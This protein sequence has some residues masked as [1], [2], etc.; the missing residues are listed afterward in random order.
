LRGRWTPDAA[1]ALLQ[2]IDAQARRLETV[3]RD[4]AQR[5]G[6]WITLPEGMAVEE[7]RGGLRALNEQ[8]ITVDRLIINRLTPPPRQ[9]CGWC[10]GR[11][12]LEREAFLALE[13]LV[14]GTVTLA[15]VPAAGKEP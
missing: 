13:R 6:A 15:T 9:P 12:S 10:D 1:D 3:L 7:T 11:R 5:E 2:E 8:N 4:P 14:E